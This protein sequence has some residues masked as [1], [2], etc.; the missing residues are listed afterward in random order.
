MTLFEYLFVAHLV[1]DWLLQTEWQALNKDHNFLALFSHIG[2]YSLVILAVLVA[3]FGFWNGAVYLVVG[4]IALT[5]GFIDRRKPVI[6]F[7]KTFRLMVERPSNQVLVLA[8]DQTFH[9]LLL[10]IAVLILS[11]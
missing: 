4:L 1:A 3:N 11:G 9:I 8:V 7:M 6:W 5:H 10:A 2:I